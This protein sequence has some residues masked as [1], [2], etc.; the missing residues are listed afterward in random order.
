MRAVKLPAVITRE[1]KIHLQLPE[2]TEE[3]PAEVI[4]LTP[5]PR[6][7]PSPGSE[8]WTVEEYLTGFEPES[9]LQRSKEEIDV[10][11]RAERESWG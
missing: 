7:A 11:L 3:G 10:D 8:T 4:V 2:G 9:G 6:E 5:D 1:R